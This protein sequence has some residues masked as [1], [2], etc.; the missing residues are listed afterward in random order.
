MSP[1]PRHVRPGRHCSSRGHGSGR[2]GLLLLLLLLCASPAR[3]ILSVE[4]TQGVDDPVRIAVVPFAGPGGGELAGVVRDDLARSGVFA[5]LPVGDMLSLPTQRRSVF[6]QDWRV[7]GMDHLLIGRVEADPGSGGRQ[8]RWELYDV[9]QGRESLGRSVPLGDGV[10]GL[11][12]RSAAHRIADEVFERITGLRGAF[13]TR[14]LYVVAEAVA[15]ADARY[16]LEMADADG[17]RPRVLHRSADPLMALSWGPRGRYIVYV[18]F[19]T[20]N[21]ALFLH[22]LY[23]GSREQLTD[24]PGLNSAP[25]FSPDGS[26]LAFVLSRDGNP[27]VYVMDL[28]TRAMRR[29]TNHYGIDTEPTFTPD[30]TGLI[31]TSSRGG[32]PQIYRYVFADASLRRL[33]FL[34]DYNTR[35]R[36]LPDGRTLVYVHR[37][38]KTDRVF[39]IAVQDLQTGRMNVLTQTGMD[40]SPTVSPNGTMI[41]Y[42][43]QEHGRGILSVVSVDG[44]VKVRLPSTTGDVREPAWSP[45]L[46]D[47]LAAGSP[48]TSAER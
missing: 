9:V 31:F 18:S 27:E 40:E 33:T 24:Y 6:F 10:R 17:A 30:G 1:I 22:D 8:V 26:Q 7:L 46:P 41:M 28:E 36:L 16:R 45:F 32:R 13:S 3:A 15:T 23:T 48:A 4:I 5:P 11:D 34:G 47:A 25:A 44:R 14:I 20:G 37:R 21:S 38:E 12:P 19:E 42:A 35:G 43:T 29:I 2:R 39:N